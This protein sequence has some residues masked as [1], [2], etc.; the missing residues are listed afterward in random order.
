MPVKAAHELHAKT[1]QK[2]APDKQMENAVGA[3]N[4]LVVWENHVIVTG[5]VAMLLWAGV[6]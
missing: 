1:Q 3:V 6:Q 2:L 5:C 4:W